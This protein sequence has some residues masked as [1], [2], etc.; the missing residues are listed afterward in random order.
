MNLTVLCRLLALLCFVTAAVIGF[1]DGFAA[2]PLL[3]YPWGVPIIEALVSSGLGLNVAAVWVRT[4][5]S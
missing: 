4:P 1:I 3:T 2:S 5:S